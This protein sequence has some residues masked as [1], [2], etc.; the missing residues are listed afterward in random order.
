[1]TFRP[2]LLHRSMYGIF[3]DERGHSIYISQHRQSIR[4]TLTDKRQDVIFMRQDVADK[5]Q[6]LRD[7]KDI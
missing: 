6:G 4:H 1:M 5:S 7:I 2:T 3:R